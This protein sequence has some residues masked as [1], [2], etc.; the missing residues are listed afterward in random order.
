M[1]MPPSLAQQ[2]A[3]FMALRR[4]QLQFGRVYE[5]RA[6][7]QFRKHDGVMTIRGGFRERKDL[8]AP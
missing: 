4:G 2:I 8:P 7:T 5:V 3:L 1:K 6:T